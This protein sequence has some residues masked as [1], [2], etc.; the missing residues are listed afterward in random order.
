MYTF[1][2]MKLSRFFKTNL[3]ISKATATWGW[4]VRNSTLVLSNDIIAF[5]FWVSQKTNKTKSK[6]FPQ[7]CT[8]CLCVQEAISLAFRSLSFW[9]FN[10]F[11]WQN[12]Q[13]LLK[14]FKYVS[15]P[16]RAN[17]FSY[18]PFSKMYWLFLF[19]YS[20]SWTLFSLV[21][22]PQLVEC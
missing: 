19:A 17:P 22:I 7:S 16:D 20:S 3:I 1:M 4:A 6:L 11:L 13:W 15:V 18:F 8:E 12:Y 9:T 2:N 14:L 5:V 21:C 10:L